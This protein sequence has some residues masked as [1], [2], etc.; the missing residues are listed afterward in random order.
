[1]LGHG[2]KVLCGFVHH[3]DPL[4]LR[5]KGLGLPDGERFGKAG[6][7][8]LG[9]GPRHRHPDAGRHHAQIRQPE[10]LPGLLNHLVLLLVVAV[11]TDGTV[12]GEK[13]EGQHMGKDLRLRFLSGGV[14]PHL[15]F[16]LRHRLG[17]GP[18]GG[19]VGC[20]H[21]AFQAGGPVQ[22]RQRHG[23]DGGRTVGVGDQLRFFLKKI[24]VHLRHHQGHPRVHP[25]G[26]G[27]VDDHRAGFQGRGDKLPRPGGPG[28]EK[29]E[30]HPGKGGG[31]QFAD[32][33]LPS[34]KDRLRPGGTLARQRHQLSHGEFP[35]LQHPQD[36]LADRPGHAHNRHVI[37]FP[38]HQERMPVLA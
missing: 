10:D 16:Q 23:K 31:L 1:M 38:G 36:F 26:G 34:G 27:V 11:R 4:G 7:H 9:M 30:I 29:G 5:Q 17:P 33:L 6:H 21:H 25:E 2:K 12:V 37:C 3:P 28:A 24:P 20:H 8:R 15:F 18:A 13:I 35:P 32:L 14:I 22:G 19:L